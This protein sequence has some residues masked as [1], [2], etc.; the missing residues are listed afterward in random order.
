MAGSQRRQ[1]SNSNSDDEDNL[2]KK[3]YCANLF[4][5][6]E[7]NTDNEESFLR[8]RCL[9]RK[10]TAGSH[11][12]D[13]REL[14]PVEDINTDSEEDSLIK[15]EYC[16]NFFLDYEIN[17]DNE[18]DFLRVR[19]R[20]AWLAA[21]KAAAAKD[22]ETTQAADTK[23]TR[24]RATGVNAATAM[25]AETDEGQ[26]ADRKA[27]RARAAAENAAAAKDE[28]TTQAADAKT[29]RTR[30]AGVNAATAMAAETDEGQAAERKASRA[31]A[32]AENA[33]AAKDEE[34]TQ[35][36]DAKTTR[37][38]AAGVN[39]AT[40]M[41]AETDE[42]QAAERK[43]SRARAAAENAAA[44]KDEE[45]TQARGEAAE[46]TDKQELRLLRADCRFTRAGHAGVLPCSGS[47][48]SAPLHIRQKVHD[49]KGH[50]RRELMQLFAETDDMVRRSRRGELEAAESIS[51][52]RLLDRLSV[53]LMA[54]HQEFL[55]V[56][57]VEVEAFNGSVLV[58]E[59]MRHL[60]EVLDVLVPPAAPEGIGEAA[61]PGHCNAHEATPV[62]HACTGIVQEALSK[63]LGRH[64]FLPV[65]VAT[66]KNC[67]CRD[68]GAASQNAL[69][70][71]LR[72]HSL[73]A[74]CLALSWR[75]QRGVTNP[76]EVI[77]ESNA[78][79]ALFEL[80]SELA[81]GF[82][83]SKTPAIDLGQLALVLETVY[84]VLNTDAGIDHICRSELAL[85]SIAVNAMDRMAKVDDEAILESTEADAVMSAAAKLLSSSSRVP[86]GP[87]RPDMI[88]RALKRDL[89]HRKLTVRF[90]CALRALIVQPTHVRPWC[91]NSKEART[92]TNALCRS[93]QGHKVIEQLVR[94][95][96]TQV[97]WR[98]A[99][100]KEDR[101]PGCS[102]PRPGSM[103]DQAAE[104]AAEWAEAAVY[105]D[106]LQA[107]VD[108]VQAVES[109][110]E[111]DE[112]DE[113][114]KL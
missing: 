38:R 83:E 13:D 47:N 57:S 84:L 18:E 51:R 3:Q 80:G 30:A 108:R 43:A 50:R 82:L 44:A 105:Y 29:T 79:L 1:G 10:R 103:S 96:A 114:E 77:L 58:L 20:T 76:E 19:A 40:A 88:A 86:M 81:N 112:E 109:A 6:N 74:L 93:L 99:I 4:L 97:D 72:L 110:E 59:L 62:W 107:A 73:M 98:M 48:R 25:A 27:S 66:V 41:A 56:G 70:S 15:Q 91:S 46:S 102:L 12:T 100:L 11:R 9:S 60:V 5:D 16:T 104:V 26:A 111:E 63:A 22:E 95:T 31:R 35:A 17:T 37:T 42:G 14:S 45:T 7:I 28:E 69:M 92:N 55:D 65:C 64:G 54:Y 39:A 113:E 75:P 52:L 24:T 71:E 89:K 23:A 2:I 21:E 101:R 90:S 68:L 78:V 67:V 53:Q 94:A 85:A 87:F 36:A 33:A 32:A 34:T 8:A 61:L 106:N 49:I